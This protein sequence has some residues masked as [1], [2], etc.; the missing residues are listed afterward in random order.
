MAAR[1]FLPARLS[2]PPVPSCVQTPLPLLTRCTSSKHS[3]TGKRSDQIT[4]TFVCVREDKRGVE[5]AG[6][7]TVADRNANDTFYP[8]SPSLPSQH[9]LHTQELFSRL[10][11]HDAPETFLHSIPLILPTGY[12]HYPSPAH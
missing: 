10:N 11:R 7:T 4:R 1:H 12:H 8:K 2:F 9:L 3:G 6:P 5:D